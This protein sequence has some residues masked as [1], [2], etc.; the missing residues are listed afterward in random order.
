MNKIELCGVRFTPITIDSL[1][2]YIE[3]T[4]QK[5]EHNLILNVNVHAINL[6]QDDNLF[7]SILNDAPL[8]FC[9]GFGV[10]LGAWILNHH[11]P[12]RITYADWMEKLAEFAEVQGFSIFFLGARPTVAEKAAETLIKQFPKLKIAGYHDGYF[13]KKIDSEEN[14]RIIQMINDSQ[15]NILL[16]SFGMPAQ[17]KWLAANWGKLKVHIGLAGGAALDYVAGETKRGPKWMTNYGLEWLARLLI[18]PKRLWRRYIIGN[19]LF[20]LRVLKQRIQMLG[21]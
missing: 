11:V 19:P 13:D 2:K 7:R 21:D 4:I 8:V 16:V 20:V 14:L 18:E 6:A 10:R 12:P 3:E 9:D 17:E 1:H 15:S 5:N